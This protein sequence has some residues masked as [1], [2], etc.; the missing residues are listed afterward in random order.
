M[1]R[2]N[3]CVCALRKAPEQGCLGC[4]H[5]N[6]LKKISRLLWH[7][8]GY[9]W[10]VSHSEG[11]FQGRWEYCVMWSSCGLV[12][13]F[14]ET[15]PL[16]LEVSRSNETVSTSIPHPSWSLFYSLVSSLDS[17]LLFTVPNTINHA[18]IF[19]HIQYKVSMIMYDQSC[20]KYLAIKFWVMNCSSTGG[21]VFKMF[22]KCGLQ[23]FRSHVLIK[24]HS[25]QYSFGFLPTKNPHS[26]ISDLRGTFCE[27]IF[28]SVARNDIMQSIGTGNL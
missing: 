24:T 28:V 26:S 23:F 9:V 5:G 18:T 13:W 12:D 25:R 7:F 2:G 27:A 22:L 17:C 8:W 10:A 6:S 11:I 20:I 16:L 21:H 4:G 14:D 3:V 19:T 15:K 1:E